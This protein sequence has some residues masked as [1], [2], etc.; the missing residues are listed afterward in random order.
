HTLQMRTHLSLALCITFALLL[1]TLSA[2]REPKPTQPVPRSLLLVDTTWQLASFS[3]TTPFAVADIGARMRLNINGTAQFK[4]SRGELRSGSWRLIGGGNELE[5]TQDGVT[6][7]SQILELTDT[8]LRLRRS[9]P[10]DAT[11]AGGTLETI[12]VAVE[13]F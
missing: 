4:S 13:R 10:P 6:T 5:L 9:I 2:C 11:Q 3:A 12:W 7:V 8:R 1:L